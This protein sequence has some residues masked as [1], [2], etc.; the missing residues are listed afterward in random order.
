MLGVDVAGMLKIT[1]AAARLNE[2]EQSPGRRPRMD[3][4]P[5]MRSG[6]VPSSKEAAYQDSLCTSRFEKPRSYALHH[7]TKR[8]LIKTASRNV[9]HLT[10]K[11]ETLNLKP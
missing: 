4:L 7:L 1:D 6:V 9:K 11:T 5:S 3:G 10:P 2:A 8:L